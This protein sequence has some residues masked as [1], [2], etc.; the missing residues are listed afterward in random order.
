MNTREKLTLDRLV[1]Q[2]LAFG[3][4]GAAW[5]LGRILRR[6]HHVEP[7]RVRTIVVA[8]LLGMGS[9]IQATPL[10]HALRRR[11]PHAR[12][13]F[14]TSVANRALIE[15]LPVIDE[16]VYLRDGRVESLALD[17]AAALASLARRGVDLYFDLEVYSAGASILAL[18]S[19]AR[20]RYGFYRHSARFKKGNY[21]HLVF[22]NV[23]M[24]V[25]RLYLQLYHAAGGDPMPLPE[26][27]PIAVSTEDVARM[28]E[29]LA[30]LGLP[31]G[32]PYLV[33]NVNASDL[34]LERR[35]PADRFVAAIEGLAEHGHRVVLI[36][37][38]GEAAY[39]KA[40]HDRLS[41]AARARTVDSAG[42]ITLVD[43]FALI[44]EARCVITN[45]TG[46]MHLAIALDRPTVCLFGPGS[47]DH[48]GV[49][50]PK[51]DIL[52]RSVVCSPCIYETDVPPCDGHN[53]CMQLIEPAEVV[54]AALRLLGEAA[55]AQASSRRLPILDGA[56]RYADPRGRPL[57]VVARASITEDGA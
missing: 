1:A 26:L 21:T 52:Y 51:I 40:I 6:D 49:T 17:T 7:E 19:L 2:P 30:G 31:A 48:Y 14:L 45:D 57:G 54:G 3:L 42:K 41:P 33:V 38:P 36:G 47:P 44:K 50:G 12:I 10:L 56:V 5:A 4:T 13:V 28:R 25:A 27:G 11:F 34:L 15:R 24:P 20:N 9:I 39:V 46:P 16:A 37:A 43:V 29:A 23:R 53:V 8:K 55:S 18:T 35:W 32:E 22:F